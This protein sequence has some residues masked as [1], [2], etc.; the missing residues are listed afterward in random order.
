MTDVIELKPCVSDIIDKFD[1]LDIVQDR[2]VTSSLL[3]ADKFE[4]RHDNV[5]RDI[6][7]ILTASKLRASSKDEASKHFFK[8]KYADSKGEK[9]SMYY[10]D[11]DGFC[12]LVMGFT[13]E[14]ADDWKW[15]FIKAFNDMEA[16]LKRYH[17][18]ELGRL[19]ERQK[20]KYV[21]RT[22]TDTI[23]DCVPET[24]NKRFMYKNYTDL[25]YK[26]L[27]G[28]NCKKLKESLGLDKKASLRDYMSEDEIKRVE[29]IEN[30]ISSLIA[31]NYTYT[32]IKDILSKKYLDTDN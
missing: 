22:L 20:S 12:F 8:S 11:R 4:K 15:D 3:V 14:K 25:I 13:G 1:L 31:S 10:M 32:E 6:Q 16:E 30:L 9:R 19:L 26:M 17:D 7:Q 5:L 21:R 24:P 18:I 2:P 28:M 23:K 27:Y 29:Q